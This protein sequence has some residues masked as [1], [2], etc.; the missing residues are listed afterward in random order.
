MALRLIVDRQGEI[1]TFVPEESWSVTAILEADSPPVFEAKL[2][3]QAGKKA[4]IPNLSAAKNLVDLARKHPFEIMDVTRK[5]RMRKPAPP[6][7]TSTL[8][9]EAS[10]KLKLTGSRTMRIAQQLYEGI[11]LGREG[12]VGLITYMRTDSP[13]IAPEATAA[14]RDYINRVFGPKYVPGKPNIYKGRK[15]AQEAHEAIRPTSLEYS[16]ETVAKYLD[17]AQLAVYTLIWNRFLSSQAA[18]AIFDSTVATIKSGSLTFRITGSIMKFDGFMR[19]YSQSGE[20]ESDTDAEKEESGRRLPP[21]SPGDKLSLKQLVPRQHFSQPPAAFNEASLIKELEE[22]GIGRPST[23]A[24][25]VTTIQKRKYVEPQDKKFR[26][27]LLGRI[28]AGLLI[29]NF[30]HLL[31]TH[32]TAEMESSLDLIEEGAAS[33]K[34]TLADFYQPFQSALK[35]AKKTMK[36]IKKEGI[37]T[38]ETCPQCGDPVVVRSGKYGLFIGCSAYPNCGY[39]RNISTDEA[40][41]EAVATEEKCPQCG[42]HIEPGGIAQHELRVDQDVLSSRASGW[43]GLGIRESQTIWPMRSRGMCTV[44]R[45]G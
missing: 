5:E 25:T 43:P 11:D 36:N 23:Y 35:E 41:R 26:P 12:A 14:A 37:P 42:S 29:E 18:P 39:T 3:E 45:A 30:P 15:S 8:Q 34:Q 38:S 16:P 21:L 20:E 7:I 10:R 24:E 33:L 13:R 17:K 2:V 27:T 4:T 22:L 19:I 44:V 9:Q 28:I 1:D 31:D 32:F 6:F 40:A